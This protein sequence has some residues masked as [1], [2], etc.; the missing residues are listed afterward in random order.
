MKLPTCDMSPLKSSVR[1][2]RWAVVTPAFDS[3]VN[4]ERISANKSEID[5]APA[6]AT[7]PIPLELLRPWVI[8]LIA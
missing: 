1:I 2:S 7:L 4:F 5:V 6:N 8:A 3:S